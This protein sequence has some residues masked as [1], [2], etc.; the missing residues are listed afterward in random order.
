MTGFKSQMHIIPNDNTEHQWL[1]SYDI[2]CVTNLAPHHTLSCLSFPSSPAK[3]FSGCSV[4]FIWGV[5]PLQVLGQEG[6]E[7]VHAYLHLHQAEMFLKCQNMHL[8]MQQGR[9]GGDYGSA[10][11][12]TGLVAAS[13]SISWFSR[14]NS[15][16]KLLTPPSHT[17]PDC[18]VS[19]N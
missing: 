16:K 8:F 19:R 9:W 1:C 18:L 17:E 11:H 7:R 13:L 12:V 5:F 15:T 6:L 14:R 10:S 3:H 2:V 4:S